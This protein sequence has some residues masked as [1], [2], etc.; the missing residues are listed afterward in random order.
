MHRDPPE[1]CIR[2]GL[3]NPARHHVGIVQQFV[4][5]VHGRCGH[6]GV[7]KGLQGLLAGVQGDPATHD[8]IDLRAMRDPCGIVLEARVPHHIFTPHQPILQPAGRGCVA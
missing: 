7:C 4:N 5:I 1:L 3:E 6:R 2:Q 8:G